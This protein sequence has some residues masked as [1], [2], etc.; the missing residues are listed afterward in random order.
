MWTKH[1]N[2]GLEISGDYAVNLG[3]AAETRALQAEESIC[4]V[5]GKGGS[6]RKVLA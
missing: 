2:I 6:G 5:G 1:I 4:K 3:L